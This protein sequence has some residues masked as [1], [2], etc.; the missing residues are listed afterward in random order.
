MVFTVFNLVPELY[1]DVHYGSM[2]WVYHPEPWHA[3]YHISLG[4]Y[5]LDEP[6]NCSIVME[7]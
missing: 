5:C 1:A 7:V 3:P 2:E 6:S 4:W